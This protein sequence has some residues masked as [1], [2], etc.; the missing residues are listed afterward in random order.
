MFTLLGRVGWTAYAALLA[1]FYSVED[2]RVIA[3]FGIL[4]P[5]LASFIQQTL[6]VGGQVADPT[7]C[8]AGWVRN[9]GMD[10]DAP[11]LMDGAA[12]GF[13]WE[14]VEPEPFSDRPNLIPEEHFEKVDEELRLEMEAGR[15]VPRDRADV[16]GCSALMCVDKE[17]SKKEKVRVVHDL[18]GGGVNEGTV[19]FE[20]KFTTVNKACSLLRPAACMAKVDLSKAYRSI[21]VAPRHWRTHAFRWKGVVYSD[22]RLPFG[23]AAAPGVFDRITQA[24]VRFMKAKGFPATLGYIDDFFVV[25]TN[26]HTSSTI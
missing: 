18:T 21:P 4:L 14:S 11:Y 20:R 9:F 24:I 26:R 6:D 10:E 25:C 3:K 22:L 16:V 13:D 19:I 1:R 5:K 15:V 2:L 23:N 7:V 8:L 12:Y 17:H